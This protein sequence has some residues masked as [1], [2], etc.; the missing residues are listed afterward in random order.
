MVNVIVVWFPLLVATIVFAVAVYIL[1]RAPHSPLTRAFVN[2]A[3]VQSLL[4]F[5]EWGYRHAVATAEAQAWVNAGALWPL[6]PA[7]LFALTVEI[8][9]MG[10]RR[11]HILLRNLMLPPALAFVALG[12]LLPSMQ[13]TAVPTSWGHEYALQASP[14]MNVALLWALGVSLVV[15]IL[16][17]R[18]L[19]RGDLRARRL[20]RCFLY[21]IA[22]VVG[23]NLLQSL[24]CVLLEQ[25]IPF[26]STIAALVLALM[27]GT[28]TLRVGVWEIAPQV[29]AMTVLTTMQ[30]GVVVVD[31]RSIVRYIN[32]AAMRILR[33]PASLLG[34]PAAE[35][36]PR[37]A[38]EP[39][40]R[41]DDEERT[42]RL[43]DGAEVRVA[44]SSAP[45]Q[46]SFGGRVYVF[47]DISERA[48]FKER[49]EHLAYY[50]TLSGL[51]NR[52][53]FQDELSQVTKLPRRPSEGDRAAVLM[54]VD[55]DRFKEVN[56]AYGHAAGDAV[57]V[58]VARRLQGAIRAEDRAY[59]L[60]GDEFAVILRHV[61]YPDDAARI[62]RKLQADLAAPVVMGSTRLEVGA[63][64][65]FSIVLPGEGEDHPRA[66]ADAALY[67]A[68]RRRGEIRSFEPGDLLP[69]T[70]RGIIHRAI[71]DAV[72]DETLT[73]HFQPIVDGSG[74]ILG[75]EALARL[76][77]VDGTP[78]SPAEFIPAAEESG[79]IREVG[80][81]A[82][83]RAVDVLDALGRP[84]GFYITV[85]VSPLEIKRPELVD[86]ILEF[87]AARD[88]FDAL[89]L[90]ITETEV[91]ELGPSGRR[92]LEEMVE[93]GVRFYIDDFGSGYSSLGRLR[94]LPI[95]AVKVDRSFLLNW[96]DET[97][98]RALVQ[99]TVRLINGLGLDLV[100]EGV[101]T[102]EQLAVLAEAGCTKYQGYYFHRP[103]TSNDLVALVRSYG[104]AAASH[105]YASAGQRIVG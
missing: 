20:S 82:R 16:A 75:A 87:M 100:A 35:A 48:R 101:E 60:G 74:R 9:S 67:E 57:I 40:G 29:S 80:E 90:E 21:G 38:L 24:M 43:R 59:R 77:D 88:V 70:R 84:A 45:I 3:V 83:R 56:D 89:H 36:V 2:F 44:F 28:A 14:A 7:T 23:I 104:R 73:W 49:L 39:T 18:T 17:V 34:R 26:L 11:P 76:K 103:V 33:L 86:A 69:T 30:D 62:G 61:R 66:R 55:L 15:M 65:G 93:A 95:S 94:T 92:R 32:P 79:I 19:R 58:E 98:A 4:A 99:G 37:N 81:L 72:R 51:A 25:E 27:V 52:Q 6:L 96:E 71:R 68:K 10:G 78:L 102:E 1:A 42:L 64:I 13:R 46:S 53:A 97:N 8:A 31:D 63:S 91:L 54:L 12:F 41:I 85:N 22:A 50:D 105:V 47:R 5:T